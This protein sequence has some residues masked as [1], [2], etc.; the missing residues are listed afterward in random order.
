[1]LISSII[2]DFL[3]SK[4]KKFTGSS[5]ISLPSL[6][7]NSVTYS[8]LVVSAYNIIHLEI[9]IIGKPDVY[10]FV[11]GFPPLLNQT[12]I[13]SHQH[14]VDFKFVTQVNPEDLKAQR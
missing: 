13:G 3:T 14:L 11:Q 8:L 12:P 5:F 2:L 9:I 1:M 4:G 7:V 6:A 10:K